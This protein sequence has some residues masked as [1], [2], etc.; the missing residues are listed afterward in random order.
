MKFGIVGR[1]SESIFKYQGWP[2]VCKDENGV[3]YAACSG[4]RLEH[5]CPFGKNLLY[6]SYD[7]GNSWSAPSIINDTPLDDRDAG[8]T[9]LGDG[10]MLMTYFNNSAAFY[11]NRDKNN[12]AVDPFV[13]AAYKIWEKLPEEEKRAGSY[14]MLSHD[15]GRSFTERYEAPVSSPHG[16]VKLSDGRLLYLGRGTDH[17][18]IPEDGIYACE[19]LDCGKTWKV[20]SHIKK[21]EDMTDA[22]LMCEPHLVELGDRTLL[23]AI[24]VQTSGRGAYFTVYTCTSNDRGREWTTPKATGICGSPPHMILHS[25][26]AIILTYARRAGELGE[27]ARISLDNGKTWSEEKRISP[28][29]PS[30]DCGY[31]SSV[32]LSDGSIITV[33]YQR[34]NDDNYCSILY[35]VWTLDETFGDILKGNGQ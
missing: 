24:R 30:P 28:P 2:T 35:T 29:S 15:G 33:Y 19:S 32:E 31:P 27:Y 22:E 8:L 5:V 12:P 7:E 18:D 20:I 14:C 25:S 17:K 26:G 6:V 10:K 3:L 9:P 34:Y 21:S 4:H 23:G 13:A 1:N 11:M 16:P